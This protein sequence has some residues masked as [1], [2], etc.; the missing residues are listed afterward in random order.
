MTADESLEQLVGVLL[1]VDGITSNPASGARLVPSSNP[2][3]AA[4]GYPTAVAGL[5]TDNQRAN[6]GSSS[7]RFEANGQGPGLDSLSIDIERL[8][9]RQQSAAREDALSMSTTQA[10]ES[11]GGSALMSAGKTLALATGIGPLTTGLLKLFGGGDESTDAAPERSLWSRPARLDVEAALDG[12]RNLQ[13]FSY[14]SQGNIRVSSSQ[15]QQSTASLPPVQ[16]NVTAMD[17]RSFLE[18]SDDIARAVREALL[19]SSQLSD[20]MSEF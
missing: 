9:T 2:W 5:S 3:E 14:S 6:Q 4:D 15:N 18:H 19:R 8:V 11:S 7:A 12:E 20:V 10:R 1:R 13:A 17:S 16:V